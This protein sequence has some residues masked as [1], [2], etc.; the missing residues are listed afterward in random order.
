VSR[1]VAFEPLKYLHLC[2]PL[3]A[4]V[5]TCEYR[6]GLEQ[7]FSN[8]IAENPKSKERPNRNNK[9]NN[10]NALVKGLPSQVGWYTP[11]IPAG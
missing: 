4:S 1:E 7:W 10:N 2:S 3:W 5:S 11:V 6:L 8:S 9:N